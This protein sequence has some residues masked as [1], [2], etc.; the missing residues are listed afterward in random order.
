VRVEKDERRSVHRV[1]RSVCRSRGSSGSMNSERHARYFFHNRRTR[2]IPA[3]PNIGL[4]I[5]PGK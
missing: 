4:L 3:A 5:R 1:K 2:K